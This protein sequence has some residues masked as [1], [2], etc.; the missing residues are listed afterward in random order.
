MALKAKGEGYGAGFVGVSHDYATV[1]VNAANNVVINP[2]AKLS[3]TADADLVAN[4]N[5]VVTDAYSFA[6][7]SGLFGHVT[8]NAYNDTTLNAK[9]L[10]AT[11]SKVAA[12]PRG[13]QY[14]T[15]CR[16]P[17]GCRPCGQHQRHHRRVGQRPYRCADTW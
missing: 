12:G 14:P 9:V 16:A 2:G 6:Q 5:N 10:A 7:A 3:E 11:G 15:G 8:S 4:F 1:D 17:I 13:R